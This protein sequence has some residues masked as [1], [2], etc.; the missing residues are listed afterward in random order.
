MHVATCGCVRAAEYQAGCYPYVWRLSWAAQAIAFEQRILGLRMLQRANESPNRL[1]FSLQLDTTPH[2]PSSRPSLTQAQTGTVS[3]GEAGTV[4]PREVV[5]SIKQA[6]W[7]VAT[8]RHT[9]THN[10]QRKGSGSQMA[11]LRA[12]IA[13]TVNIQFLMSMSAGFSRPS[14]FA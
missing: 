7:P 1:M 9:R 8:H 11:K 10:F 2:E 13:M 5:V 3:S 4:W 14:Q 12:S 6:R